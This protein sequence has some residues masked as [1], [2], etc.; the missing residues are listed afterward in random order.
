MPACGRAALRPKVELAA[1]KCE[2][3]LPVVVVELRHFS[4]GQ[5]RGQTEGGSSESGLAAQQPTIVVRLVS[6]PV[7]TT[8]II[9]LTNSTSIEVTNHPDQPIAST[10]L[11]SHCWYRCK[12]VAIDQLIRRP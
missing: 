7:L 10:H 9:I 4:P 1:S 8:I 3:D 5:S 2:P 11:R 12:D 6:S